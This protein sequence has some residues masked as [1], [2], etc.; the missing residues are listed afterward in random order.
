MRF[1]FYYSFR[2]WFNRTWFA[3]SGLKR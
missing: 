2:F 1:G 3:A